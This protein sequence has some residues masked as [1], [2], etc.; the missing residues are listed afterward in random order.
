MDLKQASILLVDDELMLRDIMCEW[1]GRVV[2]KVFCVDNGAQA[3]QFLRSHGVDLIISDV[4]MPVMDGIAMLKKINETRGRRPR[5]IF[6]TGFSDL[7]LREALDLG[8]EAVLEKPI[9]REDLLEEAKRSL[10]DP[11]ELW[12]KPLEVAP[13]EMQLKI[14]FESFAAAIHEKQIAIGRRGFCIKTR[15]SLNLGPV[16]FTLD[17]KAD[18]RVISG[19]GVVRWTLP[20][21]QQAGIEVMHLDDAGRAWMVHWMR[22]DQPIS[23]IPGSTGSVQAPKLETA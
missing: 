15:S 19:Q 21:A 11:D 7:P 16:D 2:R 18:R 23:F 8:A 13:Q 10:T 20:Q 17:F 4:R 14:D 3:L 12:Q 1:L 9:R 22:Q 5:V 6:I